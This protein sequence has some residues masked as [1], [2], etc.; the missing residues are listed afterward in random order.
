MTEAKVEIIQ[1][2]HI[3]LYLKLADEIH[4]SASRVILEVVSSS[5]SHRC[6]FDRRHNHI[7]K[8]A[9]H[10]ETVSGPLR[11]ESTSAVRNHIRADGVFTGVYNGRHVNGF[12]TVIRPFVREN[13]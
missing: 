12:P 3:V 9:R 1:Y 4:I 6:V 13:E 7:L 2:I 10:I 5:T 8:I 11:A